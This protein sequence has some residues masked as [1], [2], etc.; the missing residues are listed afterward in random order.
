MSPLGSRFVLAANVYDG[1][2]EFDSEGVFRGF[3]GAPRVTPSVADVLWSR[4]ATREQRERLALFLPANYRTL[5]IDDKGFHATERNIIKGLVE[6]HQ[7]SVEQGFFRPGD[8]I[9]RYPV[10]F[11]TYWGPRM[12]SVRPQWKVFTYDRRGNLLYVFGPTRSGRLLFQRSSS[13]G[14]DRA[15]SAAQ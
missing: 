14:H 9:P 15:R 2:M 3:I 7:C 11:V 10:N 6:R 1:I 5:D 8:C 13:D 12:Y 4:L